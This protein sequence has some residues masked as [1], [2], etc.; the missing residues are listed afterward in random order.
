[1]A[2]LEVGTTHLE[3]V[4]Y[5]SGTPVVFV[6]GGLSDLRIWE[7]QTEAF[8]KQYRAVAYSF[9]HYHPNPPVATGSDITH[10]VL[11]DDL[12]LLLGKLDLAPAHL[13]G[14]STGA[15]VSL[16]LARDQPE[17]VR[18]LTLA[19]PP[20]LPLLD[21]DV[22]P[23]PTQILR[24]LLRDPAT[25]V[26]VIKFG[27]KGLG[28]TARAFERGDDEKGLRAFVTAVIGKETV[29]GWTDEEFQRAR[30]NLGAFKAVLAAG[31]PAFGEKHARTI[32]IPTLLITGEKSAAVLHR[33][34]DKLEQL[35]PDTER[36]D[37]P[38]VSHQMFRDDP[39]AFNA[40][41]LRFLDTHNRQDSA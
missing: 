25:A 28:P 17:L 20:A 33:I 26:A 5:G 39:N 11:V 14:Q 22:P 9:R 2:S 16:L 18:S 38:G 15:F 41:V 32:D 35:I 36:V 31:M 37:M 34:T 3:Y 13:V 19:E 8:A 12:A 6:H 27:A 24:L 4:D 40:A 29:A 7:F 1:M 30:D 10:E 21:L 23:K